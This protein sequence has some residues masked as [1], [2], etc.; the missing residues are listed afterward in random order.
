MENQENNAQNS[1]PKPSDDP[2]NLV[3]TIVP[4]TE[5]EESTT[6]EVNASK[7]AENIQPETEKAPDDTLKSEDEESEDTK[8]AE[9][10]SNE[11]DN[12]QN[13]GDNIETVAP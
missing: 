8:T 13:E 5:T 4:S 12:E 1:H 7:P 2:Q 10:D 3:E 6:T 11:K 9:T